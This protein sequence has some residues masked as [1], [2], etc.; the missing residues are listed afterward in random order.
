MLS[1]KLFLF[2]AAMQPNLLLHQTPRELGS[3]G[4]VSATLAAIES[5]N[6]PRI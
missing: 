6:S 3:L 5:T 1:Q 4:P 2:P